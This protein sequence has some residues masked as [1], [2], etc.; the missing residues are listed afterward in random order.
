MARSTQQFQTIHTEGAILPPDVLQRIAANEI[1]GLE[2]S[3]YHLPTGTKTKEAI[4]QSW[5]R[6]QKYWKDFK[7]ARENI[8]TSDETGTLATRDKWLL[9]L[10]QELGYGRLTTSKSPEIEGKLFPIER[11]WQHIP[12]HLI[13]CKLELDH[14][15]KGARGAAAIPHSM[16]Q[17]FLNRSDQH[18]WGFLSNGLQLRILRDNAAL[19]RQSYVEFDLE[20]MMDGEVYAD[21][22]LLWL[23]CHQSRLEG[24]KPEDCWLEKWSKLAHEQGTR[25]LEDLRVGVQKAIEALGRGF[26]SHPRNIELINRLQ[27][28]SLSKDDY[29]RQ[30]LRIVYRL[31]FIFV[32]EDRGLLHP[33]APAEPSLR[34]AYDNACTRY[35][36]YYSL[37]RMRDLAESYRGSKHT[38]LWHSLTLVFEALGKPDGCPQL[39]LPALGSFLWSRSSTP[40]LS[41]PPQLGITSDQAPVVIRN[42]DL[43]EA[44]RSLAFVEQNKVF[45]A[46]NYRNLGS[47]ELGSVYESL[48]ELHPQINIPGRS[49]SLNVAAGNERKTSGSYYTPTSLVNCLLDSAL[50]PVV[51]DA[52]KGKNGSD[53][54][55]A[56]LKLKVCD[57]ACGSGHFLIA[58]AHRLAHHLARVRTGEA[59]ASPIEYQHSLREVIGH[60]IYGVDINPM[61]VELCKVSLWM[62]AIEPGKPLSFLDHHIQVGNSLLG[63]T[64]ALLARG[65]PDEAFDPIEGDDKALCKV[66]KKQNKDEHKGQNMLF[67]HSEAPWQ[68][69]GN[70]AASVLTQIDMLPD[71]AVG[72]IRSRE[73]KYFELMNSTTYE[74][75]RLLADTWCAA[76][77]WKKT[78]E[79]DYPITEYV[80]RNI[81]KNPHSILPWM[82]HEIR[83]QQNLFQFF[84]WHISFPDVFQPSTS[85]TEPGHL[86]WNGGFDVVLGNPPWERLNLE[87][88]QFFSTTRPDIANAS[89]TKRR[90]LINQLRVEDP[91]LYDAFVNAQRSAS[92]EIALAQRSGK[93]KFLN[94]ARL[95]TYVL[96]TELATTLISDKGRFGLIVPSGLATDDTSKQLFNHLIC[97]KKLIDLYDFENREGIFPNVD[98]RY[99][100]C[101]VTCSRTPTTAEPT[102]AFFLHKIDEIKDPTKTFTLT[103]QELKILSPSTGLS[104]TFR[105]NR[106][107]NLVLSIQKNVKPFIS[108]KIENEDWSN[109]DFLIMLRSDDSAELYLSDDAVIVNEDEGSYTISEN[110]DQAWPVLESK[111]MHQFDHKFATFLGVSNDDK[112]DGKA[113]SL[114]TSEKNNLKPMRP[115]YWIGSSIIREMLEKRSY[116]SEWTAG[117]RDITNATNER[118]AIAAILPPGGS[119]QPLNAFLAESHLHAIFW[120]LAMNSFIVD[121]VARQTIGGVH[122]NITTARQLPILAPSDK[123]ISFVVPRVLELSYTAWDLKSFANECNYLGPPFKWED[124]RRFMI[125]CELDAALFHLYGIGRDDV[126]YIM[127]TFPIVKKKDEQKYNGAYRT[128]ELILEIYDEMT[129]AQ[130]VG[131]QYQTRLDPPPGDSRAAHPANPVTSRSRIQI[132]IFEAC[133]LIGLILDQWHRPV[134]RLAAERALILALNDGIR[135]KILSTQSSSTRNSTSNQ[136]LASLLETVWKT[137]KLQNA[138]QFSDTGH[139][140]V[141]S[142]VQG[143]VTNATNTM[144][145]SRAKEA[146]N[147]FELL[148]Q[149]QTDWELPSEIY[150]VEYAIS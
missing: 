82:K 63:T 116:K 115:R 139:S 52:I 31:L 28:G 41:G 45:R 38:D 19:S 49:F 16:L 141:V 103:E 79:F 132:K 56:I 77:V 97:N 21:F 110:R 59:E 111:L 92:G 51:A 6:L 40:D 80:F 95:N 124:D 146:I 11:F 102:F 120:V 62:E 53:A 4:S 46:V 106:D 143:H 96:F 64:P 89:T 150:D 67:G 36:T 81:E 134:Q 8:L 29:Y 42:E 86:G 69:L 17:E 128:K 112:A 123:S 76:F 90:S 43:L 121:Y 57:P 2:P 44:I 101:L 37:R 140:V 39:A 65:I 109:S 129:E 83:R 58:A 137:L 118:T 74:S 12:I 100:F 84:H 5:T 91:L 126:A 88:K 145:T 9:P 26:I 147:A 105:T 136:T 61:A 68:K 144:N 117:Y 78:K 142:K 98:S 50:E 138:I 148:E 85:F 149:Q 25:I 133:E 60:C 93:Y 3:T 125:R 22:A 131:K 55:T 94:Q 47:E 13:G 24:D 15:T 32:A 122:L 130:Q 107:K 54:A 20:S 114:T 66:Y 113:R 34:S 73:E 35:D 127:E 75:G 48:L 99:K 33:P 119:A 72:D 108:Q 104:P 27:S 70:F 1:D 30:I 87:A 23:V 14:R 7:L 18:T 10:F 71:D 135:A